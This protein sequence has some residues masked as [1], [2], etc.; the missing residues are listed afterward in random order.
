MGANDVIGDL[1]LGVEGGHATQAILATSAGQIIGRGLG[2]PSNHHR[3]GIDNARRALATAIEAAFAHVQTRSFLRSVKDDAAAWAHDPRIGAACFGLSGVDGSQDEALFSSWLEGLGVKFRYV[4]RNDSE[5]VLGGGTPEG[6]GVALISG[7]G[8]ICIGRSENGRAKRVGG[9]GHVLGDE[10][11]G[12]DI[13]TQA[14]R[15]ATQA[16]DGRGG[17]QTLLQAA[18]SFWKLSDPVDLIGVV[19]RQETTAEDVANFA[20][21]VIDLASRNDAAAREIAENAARALAL[22]V[23]TVTRGLAFKTPPPLALGGSLMRATL[24]TLLVKGLQCPIGPVTTVN[25]PA[26]GAIATARRLLTTAN[27]A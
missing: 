27:A 4:V 19:C 10:G 7:T 14:L 3:V 24:R 11:S 6:W 1:V 21:R 22:H 20:A 18:L 5:L 2:P 9:W 16:A 23:D 26:Q 8:S 17:S 12:Y 25:D 13:A 15:Q